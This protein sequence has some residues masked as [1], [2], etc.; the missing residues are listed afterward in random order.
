MRTIGS[1]ALVPFDHAS[2]LAELED[3][4][5]TVVHCVHLLSV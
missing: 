5:F 3:F 4:W 1:A 2:C